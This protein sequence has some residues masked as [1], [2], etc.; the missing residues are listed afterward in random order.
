MNLCG[1]LLSSGSVSTA[2]PR[3]AAV[4]RRSELAV[5]RGRG[6][7]Y[8]WC[9]VSAWASNRKWEKSPRRSSESFLRCFERGLKCDGH[10]C[11]PVSVS[12]SCRLSVFSMSDIVG[13]DLSEWRCYSAVGSHSLHV[14]E[15]GRHSTILKT[16]RAVFFLCFCVSEQCLFSRLRVSF[17]KMVSALVYIKSR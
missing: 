15:H 3:Y 10:L 14:F 17:Y 11:C 6:V 5:K 1:P 9:S 2:S 12:L 4:R 7:V 16:E 13:V 8:L